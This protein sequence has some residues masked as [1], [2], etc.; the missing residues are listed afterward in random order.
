MKVE[1]VGLKAEHSLLSELYLSNEGR[2]IDGYSS[3]MMTAI[4]NMYNCPAKTGLRLSQLGK[5]AVLQACQLIPD[6]MAR[7]GAAHILDEAITGR[8][9]ELLHRGNQ[10]EA[11]ALSMLEAN[12]Q[13]VEAEQQEV[14]YC[15]VSGHIDAVVDGVIVELKTMS[16]NYF[17]QF[18]RKPNDDRGY[19]TQLACYSHAMGLPAL[20]LC[21]DKGTHQVRS[22][23]L[24][25][26]K[27][28][29]ERSLAR[30]QRIVPKLLAVNTLEDV[31]S[32]FS[33]PPGV[34]QIVKGEP[35]G[36][37]LVPPSMKYSLLRHLFYNIEEM[38]S[39]KGVVTE[40]IES[41]KTYAQVLAMAQT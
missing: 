24:Y 4:D 12:G 25:T 20:W 37:L 30:V 9:L 22:V 36:K 10:W 40:Y 27:E 21:L 34:T 41:S 5:P 23:P 19:I 26:V 38:T 31:F 8:M 39:N 17:R 29:A 16:S 28:E 2:F 6:D 11:W 3:R 18:T 1:A 33:P 7:Y 13:K 15:G 32:S 14:T 35:T